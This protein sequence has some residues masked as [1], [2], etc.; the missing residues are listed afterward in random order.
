MLAEGKLW[1]FQE[2]FGG[3]YHC[4]VKYGVKSL[5][6]YHQRLINF[7]LQQPE[8]YRNDI[9]FTNNGLILIARDIVMEYTDAFFRSDRLITIKE[10]AS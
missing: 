8:D 4:Y 3:L 5:N 2:H 10:K 6:D 9:T 1:H 7:M